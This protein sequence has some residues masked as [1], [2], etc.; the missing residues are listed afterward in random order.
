[1][2]EI[3]GGMLLEGDGVGGT[4]M[5]VAGGPDLAMCGAV[6]GVVKCFAPGD[7]V[8]STPMLLKS[9]PSVKIT[10]SPPSS[11]CSKSRS[12]RDTRRDAA[13]LPNSLDA[14]GRSPPRNAEGGGIGERDTGAFCRNRD[15]TVGEQ[16]LQC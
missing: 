15:A 11:A 14:T 4:T 9:G 10:V 3:E 13:S 8:A 1:M 12:V 16:V 7:G 5:G 2:S 6:E